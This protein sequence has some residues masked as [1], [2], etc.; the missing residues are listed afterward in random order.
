MIILIMLDH[1]PG[2]RA[3]NLDF[4]YADVRSIPGGGLCLED[5]MVKRVN[6]RPLICGC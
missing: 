1:D 4:L 6:A 5:S 3:C 2:L